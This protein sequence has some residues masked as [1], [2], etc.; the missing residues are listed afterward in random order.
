MRKYL[1]IL[2]VLAM[3]L[4]AC[5]AGEEDGSL[6]GR[7]DLT[8]Y[9]PAGS[10][11]PALTENEPG[12]TFNEDGTLNGSSGCNGFSGEYTIDGDQITFGPIVSTLM[13]CDSPMMG[14]EEAFFQVLMDT[15]TYQIDGDRLTL[16][17]ND[18]I[19]VLSAAAG[20]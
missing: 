8:D 12:L 16:T 15:A 1:T 10:T 9:G 20:Q 13:L 7:W 5:A 6:V 2:W 17:N 19:L 11:S 3:F 4:S 18:Q 14:Q